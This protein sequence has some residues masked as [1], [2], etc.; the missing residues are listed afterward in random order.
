MITTRGS[1]NFGFFLSLSFVLWAIFAIQIDGDAQ[2]AIPKPSA[3]PPPVPRETEEII[4]VDSDLV[5]VPVTVMDRDGR[6]ITDLA[7][8]DFLLFEDGIEHEIT[9]FEST[10][11]PFT[12]IL[13]LDVSCS[14]QSLFPELGRSADAFLNQLRKDD[15]VIIAS[16]DLFVDV[17]QKKSTISDFRSRKRKL[18]LRTRYM[19]FSNV[20]N[21]VDYAI[22]K[23]QDIKGRKA[24]VLFSDGEASGKISAMKENLRKSSEGEAVIYTIQFSMEQDV[25]R[26]NDEAKKQYNEVRSMA[27]Q[28]M[29]ELAAVSGGR[30]YRINEIADFQTTFK[31]V[32]NE[33]GRQYSL[34][35]YPKNKGKE[36]ERREIRVRVNRPGLAVRA[37][38]S[39]VVGKRKSK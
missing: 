30:H 15:E 36:G 39:Y 12:I 16:F 7:K 9:F 10:D 6:Y 11:T 21:A 20:Y 35:Y 14:M 22:G 32:A 38:D 34:G 2:D 17:L 5:T 8:E 13:L 27:N 1:T 19:G 4:R 25:S 29:Q 24:I 26:Y 3:T 31:S 33:M 37:R 23:L 18:H 28:Y